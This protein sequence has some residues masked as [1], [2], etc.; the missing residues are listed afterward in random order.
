MT[1]VICNQPD[2]AVKFTEIDEGALVVVTEKKE[3]NQENT[4]IIFT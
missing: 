3:E 4:A 1:L 2:N